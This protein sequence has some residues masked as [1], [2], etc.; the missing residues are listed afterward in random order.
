MTMEIIGQ[1]LEEPQ[2]E[3][4]DSKVD[5]ANFKKRYRIIILCCL[6]LILILEIIKS[7]NGTLQ[8]YNNCY[9]EENSL[10]QNIAFTFCVLQRK[11]CEINLAYFCL[12]LLYS[13]TSAEESANT[14][15]FISFQL[16][17]YFCWRKYLGKSNQVNHFCCKFKSILLKWKM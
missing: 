16:C 4:N 3:R 13:Y 6:F 8:W 5:A 2:Q 9:I 1:L 15:T 14:E 10:F 12:E 17:S 11:C 7:L